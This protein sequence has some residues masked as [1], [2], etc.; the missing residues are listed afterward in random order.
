MLTLLSPEKIFEAANVSSKTCL[1]C[2][3]NEGMQM[4]ETEHFRVLRVNFPASDGHVMI[5][6]KLHYGSL[7]ELDAELLPELKMLKHE[8]GNWFKKNQGAALF[9]EH[10]RAGSCHSNDPHGTQC[11]HFHLNCL[12]ANICIHSD[13]QKLLKKSYAT[14]SIDDISA[15]F[16]KWGDYLYFE[17]NENEAVYYPVMDNRIPP[18]F[19]RT[20]ICGK[21]LIPH[22]ADWQSH[23]DFNDFVS[24][25]LLTKPLEEHLLKEL[26]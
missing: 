4:A 6:S 22:K 10:G 11:E 3:P 23:Q 19:L 5:S 16:Q 1:F 12:P 2:Y 15:L 26:Q 13:L 18:H 17:N 9:Y 21:L 7:G 20:L 14:A 24:N 25:Y 8:I